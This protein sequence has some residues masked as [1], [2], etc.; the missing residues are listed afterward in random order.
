V[1]ETIYRDIYDWRGG[2]LRRDSARLLR[3]KRNRR[4]PSRLVPR[5][6]SRFGANVL[7]IADRPF[8][9]TDRTIGGHLEGDLIMG[10]NNSSAIATLVERTSRFLL[11]L[12]VDAAKRADSLRDI[13]I[14]A[15][16]ELP[17]GMRRSITWDQGWEMAGTQR[18]PS[19]PVPPSTSATSTR[20]G[21]AGPMRTPTGSCA[22]TSPNA[23]T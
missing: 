1:H 10:R 8:E 17:E 2:A 18:S 6:R 7:T 19:R 5:R 20:P 21:S 11:L 15:F 22:T 3:T 12:R 4:R 9:P 23:P 13:L 16:L 14:K